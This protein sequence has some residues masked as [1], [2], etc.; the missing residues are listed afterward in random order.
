MKNKNVVV[1]ALAIIVVFLIG[2]YVYKSNES[3]QMQESL[4]N[5]NTASA[6]Y[7]RDY[8]FVYG[9]NKSNV[10]VVEFFDPECSACASIYPM[11]K[12][13]LSDYGEDIQVVMRYMVSRSNAQ[14]IVKILEASRKQNL[15]DETLKVV[16]ASQTVWGNYKNPKPHL[17]WNY[18]VQVPGLNVDKLRQDMNDPKFNEIIQTDMEDAKTLKLT[19]TPSIFVNGRALESL[20]YSALNN[21]V[22]EELAK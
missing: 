4:K 9:K 16:L 14:N 18:I 12:K 10:T 8:S 15:Y 17:I 19:G 2:A 22:E 1:V 13:V 5:V 20:S 6:P 7:V 21:L 3:K 11:V